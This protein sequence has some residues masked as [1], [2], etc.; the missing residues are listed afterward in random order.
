[1][2]V[3]VLTPASVTSAIVLPAT[4]THSNVNSTTNPLPFGSYTS[5]AFVSGAVDNLIKTLKW[6]VID[7]DEGPNKENEYGPYFQS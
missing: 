1:M 4:V 2:A 5:T 3:P 7:Y 6:S